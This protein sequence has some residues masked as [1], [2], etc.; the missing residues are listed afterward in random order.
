[1]KYY[2]LVCIILILFGTFTWTHFTSASTK[3]INLVALGDSITYGSGDPSK[4]GYIE[5]VKVK[6]E[7]KEDIPV[8]VSNF[9]IPQYTTVN[10]LEQIN[11]RKI[12][13]DIKK[14]NYIILYIGTNDFRKSA[15]Y[16]F[17]QPNIKKINE[18]KLIYS[19][20]LHKIIDSIRNENLLAPIFLLGLYHPYVEYQNQQEILELIEGW[21]KE[22]AT[23]IGDFDQTYFVPTLDLFKNKSKKV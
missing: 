16:N 20:N 10:I 19:K 8:H 18:G 7:E 11:D 15:G 13:K 14:A 23:V 21:N 12:K 3:T 1:M 4:K 2:L 22:I 5:R 9:G 6:F 17:N